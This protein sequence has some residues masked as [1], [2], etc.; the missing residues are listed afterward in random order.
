MHVTFRQLRLFLALAETG[1][2]T[3]AARALHVTQPTASMQLR[4][5]AEAVGVP[6][7]EVVARRM[8]LTDA[9]VELARTA[10]TMVAEW[11]A[12]SQK[13]DAMKGLTRGLLK[14]SVVSTAKYFM[15]RLLGQFCERHPEID[16]SLEVL[17]RDGVVARL[18]ENRDDLY[19]MSM[20]PAELE[21]ED[22][23]FMPNPIVAIAAADHPLARRRRLVLNDLREQPFILRERGSGTRM[24]VDAH[25]RRA[26]F[27]PRVRL[28]LGSNEAIREAVAGRL[29]LAVLSRHALGEDPSRLGLA[30]LPVQG[31]PIA[32]S[33]HVVWPRGKRPSPIAEVF[34]RHLEPPAGLAGG[35]AGGAARAATRVR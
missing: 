30:V 13:V 17:N 1:S 7:Y 35:A 34:R 8:H 3:G 20:P 9:G 31:L 15:P 33:W 23:V 27:V 11:E 22:R 6:L 12:F 21:L 19:I 10:R 16:I 4:E 14:V 25:F 24:A 2:V 28:E 32:S 5:V 26:R 29:G 18:R